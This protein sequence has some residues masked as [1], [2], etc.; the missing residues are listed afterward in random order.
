MSPQFKLHNNESPS[1]AITRLFKY[2]RTMQRDYKPQSH[3]A[4]RI[5]T[6]KAMKPK[7]R[8]VK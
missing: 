7:L 3:T 4:A 2:I 8:I 1:L 5:Q 6:Q